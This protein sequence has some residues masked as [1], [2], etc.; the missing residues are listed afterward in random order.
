MMVILG[1]ICYDSVAQVTTTT[2][3]QIEN[4]VEALDDEIE[5]DQFLQQLQQFKKQPLNLNVAT[6]DD[7]QA[8]RILNPLQISSLLTYRKLLGSLLSI[9]ELQAVPGWDVATIYRVLPFVIVA[10]KL[11][12]KDAMLQRTRGGEHA[13][14]LR[15]SRIPEKQRGYNNTLPT[16]YLGAKNR[17]LFRYRYVYKNGLQFGVTGDKDAGEQFF[18][19]AQSKGF[20]FYSAHL[21]ARNV[22]AVKAIAV[23][24]FTANLGQGLIQWQALAF[25]KG[26]DV[27]NIKRQ[28]SVLQ[29]YSS[30]G[31][32][33]FNRGA[34]VTFRKG[35]LE[36]T[37]FASVKRISGNS[38]KDTLGEEV[39]SSFLLSG[40]HRTAGEVAD[41]Y[42]VGQTSFGGNVN[43]GSDLF[44]IGLNA[45]QHRFS[46]PLQKRDEPYNAFAMAG[47]H[48]LNYSIDYSVTRQNAHFFG[49]A[50][51][52]KMGRKAIVTGVL[53]AAD[54]K[55]D[56]SVLY[57][58]IGAGYQAL[59]GNAFTENVYPSNEKGFYAGIVI[60]PGPG[61]Q[62]NAYADHYTF[63]F[64]KYRVNAPG[65]G[66]D[67]L[68]QIAYQPRKQAEIYA[69]FR[70]ESK[71]INE[72]SDA[73]LR[74]IMQVSKQ[75][76]RLNLVYP[77]SQRFSFKARTDLVWYDK[78]GIT[79][80]QGF[81]IYT[82]GA[83][84]VS[85]HFAG[86][87][88]L[89]YFET[90]GYN[91]RLYAYESDVL[92]GYSIPPFFDK[93][94]RYYFNASVQVSKKLTCWLKWAQTIYQDKAIIGSGLEE[95][96]GNRKSEI[97]VQMQYIF[98][99][100]P[101]PRSLR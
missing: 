79:P 17:L 44:K 52:D 27:I 57:R 78:R 97:K 24:D 62:I 94:F 83:Y 6:A 15:S 26:A 12:V 29:P 100:N 53:V 20:D 85:R 93:G 91:S 74:S 76:C 75:S 21:F 43:Y 2:E 9:Y 41:R 66:Q 90:G 59:N 23:G 58:N 72:P 84:Q 96:K 68:L 73:T 56:L 64:I 7:L 60:R 95:I 22:G 101:D 55:V 28:A 48:W 4:L 69:R 45:V 40:F 87:L 19:G 34:G 65:T 32:Y 35:K 14:L 63:P 54:P 98:N 46:K 31:E 86:N 81:L 30:A 80:E 47:R 61:V 92:Y 1:I 77:F 18:K 99:N 33:A 71:S 10:E 50:A 36:A 25:K 8:L 67:Y 38:I 89:Q 39:F 82:E 5:D 37:G 16:H 11:V 51:L 42:N 88:R 49:E 13:L 70:S 3:Q